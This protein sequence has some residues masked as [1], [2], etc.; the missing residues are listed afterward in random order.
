MHVPVFRRNVV[1]YPAAWFLLIQV[2]NAVKT[3]KDICVVVGVVE[4][5]IASGGTAGYAKSDID[6]NADDRVTDT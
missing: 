6:L 4:Q 3:G 5:A 1:P 2:P